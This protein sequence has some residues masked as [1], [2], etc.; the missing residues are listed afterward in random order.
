MEPLRSGVARGKLADGSNS[1][2]PILGEALV[3][4]LALH[5]RFTP[6]FQR[7]LEM[8]GFPIATRC[9]GRAPVAEYLS[10]W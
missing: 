8:S 6:P 10:R 4:Q 3:H 9:A 2:R 1:P 7:S 5:E